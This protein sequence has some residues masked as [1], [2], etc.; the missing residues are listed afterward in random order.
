MK[1]TSASGQGI[2]IAGDDPGLFKMKSLEYFFS[3]D[4]MLVHHENRTK[5]FRPAQTQTTRFSP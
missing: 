5:G 1:V 4:E 2:H 3:F